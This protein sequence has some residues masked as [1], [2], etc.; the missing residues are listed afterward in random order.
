MN[1]LSALIWWPRSP[2]FP[3]SLELVL[4]SEPQALASLSCPAFC[5]GCSLIIG[6]FPSQFEPNNHHCE[7]PNK[8]PS[9]LE[10]LPSVSQWGIA[11]VSVQSW[12]F[13]TP[14]S[15]SINIS[16]GSDSKESACNERDLGSIPWWGRSPGEGNC[17]SL[18]YSCLENPM[19]RGA[20]QAIV[21]G[22]PR[23][24]HNSVTNTFTFHLL[25]SLLNK[26]FSEEIDSVALT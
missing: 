14:I 9:F 4:P 26:C 20:W 24:R 10:N 1:S 7:A 6:N 3:L 18:Q 17:N 25:C 19:D 15:P 13:S 5:S 8:M 2:S 22:V 11:E 12:C 16:S 23:I 21:H